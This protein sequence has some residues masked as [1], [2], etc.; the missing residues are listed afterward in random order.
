[1]VTNVVRL[2]TTRIDEDLDALAGWGTLPTDILPV[3][4]HELTHH[5]CFLS[6]VG[7]VISM[8]HLRAR[9]TGVLLFNGVGDTAR[10]EE[11]LRQDLIRCETATTMLRPLAEG[12]A[13]FAEFD[14]LSGPES[15]ALSLPAELTGLYFG[16]L[17]I[18]DPATAIHLTGEAHRKPLFTMRR[19]HQLTAR[20]RHL[21]Q[22]SFGMEDGGYL[23]GYLTVR[24]MWTY[25]AQSDQRL[26]NESDLFMMYLRS[27]LY[28]DWGLVTL[29]LDD[30]LGASEAGHAVITY[31][32]E[33]LDQF[34][35]VASENISAYEDVV[36]RE[37]SDT[38]GL[39]Q[40]PDD[41]LQEMAQALLVEDEV[42]QIGRARTEALN[43]DLDTP[44]LDSVEGL[45]ALWDANILRNRDVMYLGSLGV[46]VDIDSAGRCSVST[47]TSLIH[48]LDALP[49]VSPGRGEGWID[50]F[51][52][53]M[54]SVK[55][56]VSIV[57]RG[58]ERVGLAFAGPDSLTQGAR[59]RLGSF[60][61]NMRTLQEG[62][63]EMREYTDV[64]LS[65]RA[66]LSGVQE[67]RETAVQAAANITMNMCLMNVS[68]SLRDR[69]QE[70]L[71]PDGLLTILGV[72]EDLTAGEDLLDGIVML[73]LAWPLRLRRAEVA[74]RM[75]E[76]NLSLP[77]ILAGLE[78]CERKYGLPLFYGTDPIFS[79]V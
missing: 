44:D 23:A 9:R 32:A 19:S 5:W 13:L 60:D 17:D 33:R 20:K 8:L 70:M 66:S 27:F 71:G 21:L 59:T 52:S 75:D 38:D 24:N 37:H 72:N 54:T 65:Q 29:L 6:P 69:A 36:S 34:A 14:A 25:L 78:E 35:T 74:T 45:L 47:D 57:Y 18:Q 51:F 56:R 11:R 39:L 79:A 68:G 12:L 31:L 10:L 73:S 4:L 77:A 48:A 28:D 42:Y 63:Q 15:R 30:S 41:D 50:L 46:H 16:L 53:I 62:S 49:N 7:H 1:M 43:A 61:T 76:I 2:A 64:V 55:A 26:L 58:T 67:M 40:R 3:F 22:Q